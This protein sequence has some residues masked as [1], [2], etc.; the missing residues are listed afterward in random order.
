[1]KIKYN[2][3]FLTAAVGLL[4][5]LI[6]YS[7]IIVHTINSFTQEVRVIVYSRLNFIG[8]FISELKNVKALMKENLK[9]QEE[10]QKL[11]ASLAN[12]SYLKEENDFLRESLNLSVLSDRELAEAGIFNLQFTP[13][14][15]YLLMNKGAK[16]GIE[17]DDVAISSSGILIGVVSAIFE[18]YSRVHAVT[19]PDFKAT[20]RV[21]FKDISGI[22]RGA[23]G[24][25][26]YLE[27]I[28]QNDEINKG[29]VIIT[30]GSDIFPPGLIIGKVAEIGKESGNL[31]KNV[32][33]EPMLKEISLGRV[34]VIKK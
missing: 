20:I 33:V 17:K 23:M 15:H 5:F 29:D 9:L 10:N 6:L 21:L 24:N 13:K 12:Q 34:L 18:N 32:R 7:K 14:G 27:F 3:I 8:N 16:D 19:N 2:L 26:I 1:M 30:S 4:V 11:F 28:S 25:G 31:F 22:A